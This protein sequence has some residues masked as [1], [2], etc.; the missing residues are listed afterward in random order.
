MARFLLA[1]RSHEM[2]VLARNLGHEVVAVADPA[3]GAENWH[4]LPVHASDAEA[5]KVGGFGA[6]IL[7]IDDPAV[8]QRVQRFYERAGLSAA[9][10]IGGQLGDGTRHGAGLV[11][12]CFAN[13]SVDCSVGDGVRLNTGANVMHDV[14]LGDF[15]SIAPNAVL[16]G[17]VKVGSLSYIGANATVLPGVAVGHGSTVGAGAVVTRDVADGA[18]VK[19]SPAR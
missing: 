1:G 4:G 19:G 6:V 12:Q 8:R 5:V 18:T 7:A 16:L 14:T 2:L 3:C 17:G 13:L 11:I 9:D 15:V 10:L